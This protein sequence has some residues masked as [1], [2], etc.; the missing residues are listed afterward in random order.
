MD[1]A[2]PINR[3]PG[4]A[5]TRA[6]P[7]RT[8]RFEWLQFALRAILKGVEGRLE[9]KSTIR[10]D[11]L[12]V[13]RAHAAILVVLAHIFYK[14]DPVFGT[15]MF[16]NMWYDL[17]SGVDIF[18]VL[19]GFII[20][21][22]TARQFGNPAF[23]PTFLYRR[24]TRIA[25]VYWV[26]TTIML[27]IILAAPMLSP[28]VK[29]S[30]LHTLAS[31]L[32]LPWRA[33]A[34]GLGPILGVG[35][36]LLYE[37]MFYVAFSA[38][39]GLRM[40]RAIGVLGAAFAGLVLVRVLF[41][42]NLPFYLEYWT[43]PIILEFVAG[44]VIAGLYLQYSTRF[45]W[46]YAAGLI[47]VSFAWYVAARQMPAFQEQERI[48]RDG[49]PSALIV[50]ALTFGTKGIPAGVSWPRWLVFLGDTSYSLYLSHFFSIGIVMV[51]L[52]RLGLLQRMPAE[53]WILP[54]LG[55]CIAAGALSYLLIE[56]PVMK[57]A[58]RH[59]SKLPGYPVGPARQTTGSS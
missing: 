7:Q 39:I 43:N 19:S 58:R 10:L 53:A 56:K 52:E 45:H 30:P 26:Y 24:V 11:Q 33:P 14:L 51:V 46:G 21:F 50:L 57:L 32:F 55:A 47:A 35:W 44:A 13:L 34:G 48:F 2:F 12:Q 37:M 1:L 17:R 27:A 3:I 28:S 31:Y 23:R 4:L 18:F 29:T 42:P 20:V 8:F 9:T 41:F 49:V 54:L 16:D 59:E 22:I 25:P 5:A 6:R 40:W 38:V 15:Q 36:T